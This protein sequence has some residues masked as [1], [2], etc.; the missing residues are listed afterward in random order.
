MARNGTMKAGILSACIL[1]GGI[2]S[3]AV[4][5]P[6]RSKRIWSHDNMVAWTV[7][8]FDSQKRSPA[9]RVQ[10]LAGVGITKYGHSWRPG[11]VPHF[12]EDIS[13]LKEAHLELVSWALYGLDN[14]YLD[15]ILES[16]R[17]QG[18]HPQLWLMEVP[19]AFP[20]SLQDWMLRIAGKSGASKI[21]VPL[22]ATDR[23]AVDK[24]IKDYYAR[25]FP[26]SPQAQK[27]RVRATAMK[28]ERVAKRAA[29][30]GIRIGLYNHNG[31]FGEVRNEIAVID[32]L[33]T[34][35]IGN[36]GIVYNFSHAKDEFHDDSRNFPELWALMKPHVLAVNLSGISFEGQ[37]VYP[38]Q[39]QQELSMMRTIEESGWKGPVGLNTEMH[40]DARQKLIDIMRGVDW[41][42]AEI[43]APGSGGKRPFPVY[44]VQDPS[45][46]R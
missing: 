37:D 3:Q 1:L 15:N 23:V 10:M 45:I 42:A 20:K 18:V 11:D 17:R 44:Q 32:R 5:D 35:G 22:N 29:A 39:G 16:F 14:P 30:Y 9:E 43:A 36:V 4:C 27:E 41:L 24:A 46:S 21:H 6:A 12:D 33:R 31:W 34:D 38:S 8:P 26:Q 19:P 28:V 7:A 2:S 25:N 13:A 40:G